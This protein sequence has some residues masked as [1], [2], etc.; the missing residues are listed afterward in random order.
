M[1]GGHGGR[2]HSQRGAGL[3]VPAR[4]CLPTTAYV[5]NTRGVLATASSL[6]LHRDVVVACR[7]SPLHKRLQ[8]DFYEVL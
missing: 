7:W 1:G 6:A 2:G 4:L 8:A 3:L 5:C